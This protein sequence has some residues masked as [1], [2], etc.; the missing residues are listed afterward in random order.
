MWKAACALL[1]F[2]AG[3]GQLNATV[4]V[5]QYKLDMAAD[6]GFTKSYVYGVG[7]GLLMANIE[8]SKK[9]SALFCQPPKLALT[10]ENYAD[11]ID[12]VIRELSNAPASE[13]DPIPIPIILLRG[14]RETFPCSAK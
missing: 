8:A 7:E 5:R 2:T 1:L 14:L 4:N 3:V 13:I 9:G 6:N 10:I 11:I 12:R